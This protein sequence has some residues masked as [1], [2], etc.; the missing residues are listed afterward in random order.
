MISFDEAIERIRKVAVPLGIESIALEVAAGRVLASPVVARIESPRADVSAM[1]GYAVRESDLAN[2]PARL[3]LAGESFAGHGWSGDVGAGEC[4]RIFTGAPVPNGADRVVVQEDVIRE[5]DL[6]VIERHPGSQLHIRSRGGDF[7]KGDELVGTGR[8]LDPRAIIAAAAA[9]LAKLDVYLRP[10][11][12]IF[13]T[14]DELA[15]PGSAARARDSI[16]ESVSFGVAALAHQWGAEILGK[17]RLRDDLKS[18]KRAAAN[19]IVDAD[20]V[21]VTGGASVGE[22]DFGKAMFEDEGLELIY[23]KVSLKPGKPAWLGRAGNALVMGLPGNPTSALVTARLFLAPLLAGL[24]GRD[25]MDALRWRQMA[26]ATPLGECG[27]RETFHRARSTGLWA[28]ILSNQDSSA[29][30][31]LVE[32]DLLARQPANSPAREAGELVDVLDF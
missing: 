13:S 12:R 8:P 3:K 7:T 9:D 2:L 19:A 4:V 10:W 25:P 27:S 5:D 29:Q 14:G 24:T 28:E 16:P 20:V 17:A 30:K 15:E 18:M 23:S 21:I 31:T 26:L 6:L 22:K 1:D 11:I 32:A